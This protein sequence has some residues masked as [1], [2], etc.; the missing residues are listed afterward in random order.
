MKTLIQRVKEAFVK[1]DGKIIGSIEK[2]ILLFLAIEKGDDVEDINFL[3]KKITNL[4]IFPDSQGKMNLS[5]R[6]IKGGILVVSQFTLSADCRKGNRPSFDKAE[7]PERAN[8]LYELFVKKLRDE[9]FF[10]Q[11]GIFGAY[12]LV[13]LINDGPVTFL[14]ESKK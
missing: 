3:I 9:G 10:V 4:R 12:M 11:T 14:I 13:S 6:D 5:I 2:G 7:I 8:Q 1:V